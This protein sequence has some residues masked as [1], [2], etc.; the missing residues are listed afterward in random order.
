MKKLLLLLI[1][2]LSLNVSS[3]VIKIKHTYYEITFDCNLKEPLYTYYILTKNMYNG[4]F[5]RTSF[6]SDDKVSLG[7]QANEDD[8]YQDPKKM[9]YDKG[10]L[11]PDVDFTFNKKAE[12]EVMVFTNCAPQDLHFNRG[13]WHKLENYIRELCK[14]TNIEV[15][16]GCIYNG[17]TEK[18]NSLIVPKFYWKLIKYNNTYYGWLI[19]NKSDNGKDLDKFKVDPNSLLKLIN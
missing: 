3:Q 11:S 15:Y 2:L 18:L 14:K 7:T 8:Y 12:S 19:P 13:I 1:F 16:T 6:H 10:H 17:S 9:V 5:E 4:K